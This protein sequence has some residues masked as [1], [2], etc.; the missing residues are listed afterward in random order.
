MKK[1]SEKIIHLQDILL[2]LF[3]NLSNKPNEQNDS[4]FNNE[5]DKSLQ[6]NRWTPLRT[7]SPVGINCPVA[8]LQ[9]HL[10]RMLPNL[11]DIVFV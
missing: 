5:Y 10:P 2:A 4:K 11:F 7:I 8:N 9:L 6:W 1:D 3:T